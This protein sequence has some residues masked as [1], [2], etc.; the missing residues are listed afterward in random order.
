MRDFLEFEWSDG[1]SDKKVVDC[2]DHIRPS[3]FFFKKLFM[4]YRPSPTRNDLKVFS[5]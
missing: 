2:P 4:N 1:G 5:Y 3:M